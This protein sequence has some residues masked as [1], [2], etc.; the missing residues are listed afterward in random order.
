MENIELRDIWKSRDQ[1][2]ERMLAINKE[3]AV[4]LARQKLNKQIS[5]LYRPKWT[6]V[7]I[8]IPYTLFLIAI[9]I[10]A[11][12][13]EAYFVALGVGAIAL[14]TSMLLLLY[15]YQMTLIGRVKNDEGIL[16]TQRQ[17]S[18][19]RV[20]S[21]RSLTLA[22]FQLPLWSV[23]WIS[24]DALK[25]SPVIYGGINALIFLLLTYIAYW[26]YQKISYNNKESKIR[27]FFLSGN[28]WEPIIKS[29]EILE[30]IKAYKQ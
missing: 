2:M 20:S 12:V 5:R 27:D 14:I 8:G 30:Q 13:A 25:R 28:E 21:Y 4:H 18:K 17:L 24:A 16:S 7:L 6:A 10:I 15:F 3:M 1:K 23:C 29:T 11:S 19:L 22:I 9:T 26:L